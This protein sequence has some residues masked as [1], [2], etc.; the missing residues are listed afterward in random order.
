MFLSIFYLLS[1]TYAEEDACMARL[2]DV[3]LPTCMNDPCSNECCAALSFPEHAGCTEHW[4]NTYKKRAAFVMSTCP[5]HTCAMRRPCPF[6][7]QTTDSPCFNSLCTA[8]FFTGELTSACSAEISRYCMAHS[9][10]PCA[11]FASNVIACGVTGSKWYDCATAQGQD[12]LLA[13]SV[14]NYTSIPH[15]HSTFITIEA[16][17]WI[18][19]FGCTVDATLMAIGCPCAIH[20]RVGDKIRVRSCPFDYIDPTPPDLGWQNWLTLS[21]IAISWIVMEVFSFPT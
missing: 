6:S 7:T 2:G 1:S 19:R 20:D 12:V 14:R 8:L 15:I 4:A 13:E 16:F 11:D 17:A 21:A 3:M 5:R 10:Q 9:T 18:R